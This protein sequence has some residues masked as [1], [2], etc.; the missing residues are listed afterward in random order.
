MDITSNKLK[1]KRYHI[2][3]TV[4]RSSRKSRDTTL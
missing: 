3:G 4:P 2:V 1:K